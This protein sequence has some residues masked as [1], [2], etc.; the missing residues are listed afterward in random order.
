MTFNLMIKAIST[1]IASILMLMIVIALGGTAY[2]Y[3]SGTFTGKT[4]TTFEVIDAIG[5]TVAIRNSGTETINQLEATLDGSSVD[6]TMPN[7]LSP[8]QVIKIRPKSI[9]PKGT[10]VLRLCTPSMCN[11]ALLTVIVEYKSCLEILNSGESVGDGVY[12]ITPEGVNSFLVY[13]DMTTDGGGWTLLMRIPGG[14][15]VTGAEHGNSVWTSDDEVGSVPSSVSDLGIQSVYKSKSFS[16]LPLSEFIIRDETTQTERSTRRTHWSSISSEYNDKP[17]KEWVSVQVFSGDQTCSNANRVDTGSGSNGWAVFEESCVSPQDPTSFAL[18]VQTGND[19]NYARI[20]TY[21]CNTGILHEFAG[22]GSTKGC[23]F[24]GP[25]G[26]VFS[27]R[28]NAG[29]DGTIVA[30]HTCSSGVIQPT[31]WTFWGK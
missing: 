27:M 21:Y 1:V 11:T 18:Y 25:T 10:H 12:S 8:G 20:V 29:C 7:S 3:I 9:L 30:Q 28:R 5:S 4:A 2:L 19:G 26:G 15:G 24:N 6:L 14:N 23:N 16:Y 31:V 22:F 17:L 13:C